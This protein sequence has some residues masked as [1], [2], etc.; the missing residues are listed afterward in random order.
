MHCAHE[1][2]AQHDPDEGGEDAPVG[3][4]TRADDRRSAGDGREVVAEE[5]LLVGRDEVTAI[6]ELMG[7]G[8]DILVVLIDALADEPRVE[9]IAQEEE[10]DLKTLLLL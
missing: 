7:R 10:D 9:A 3:G 4:H 8:Q 6:L 2:R 1:D 5:D